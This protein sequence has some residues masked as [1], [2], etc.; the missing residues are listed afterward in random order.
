MFEFFLSH[1]FPKSEIF[2]IFIRYSALYDFSQRIASQINSRGIEERRF[3]CSHIFA[4]FVDAY[5]YDA[6]SCILLSKID[7]QQGIL[8]KDQLVILFQR[9]CLKECKIKKST[10]FL[11]LYRE[12]TKD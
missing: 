11:D 6:M 4:E 9:V 3:G 8:Y 2:F 7:S 12:P 5:L 1:P 10:D